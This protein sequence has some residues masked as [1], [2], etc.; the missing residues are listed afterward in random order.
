MK[1]PLIDN[2]NNEYKDYK[3]DVSKTK[4]YIW[5]GYLSED[6][7]VQLEEDEEFNSEIQQSKSISGYMDILMK[8]IKKLLKWDDDGLSSLLS[9]HHP[10]L[11]ASLYPSL[12]YPYNQKYF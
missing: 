4:A 12:E 1:R 3:N 2:F 6:F 5:D 10:T 8:G 7:K 9:H 11:V